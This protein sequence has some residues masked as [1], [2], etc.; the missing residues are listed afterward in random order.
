MRGN[1]I[2]IEEQRWGSTAVPAPGI[3][4]KKGTSVRPWL[5][6]EGSG[7]AEVVEVGKHAIM[8]RT[9]L[10]ARDLRILDPLLSYPSTV[11]G[12]ERA[13]VINLEHIKAIITANQVLLLNSRDPSVTPFVQELQARILR[14][15]QATTNHHPDEGG[16]KIL[17]FEFVALEACLE[18][19]CSVLENEAKTLEQEAHP[20]LDKLT[21]KIS[22]LNLE[23]VRQIKSRLVAITGRVQ[24]V[25]DELEHLLDDDEDMAEMYLTEKLLQQQ[26]QQT[27]SEEDTVVDDTRH[28]DDDNN[29]MDIHHRAEISLEAGVGG[30]V[31]SYEEEED[32]DDDDHRNLRDI[33]GTHASTV[34][35]AATIKLDVEEL[36]M[37]LE[38]YFVQI[39]GTLNKLSTLREYV[40]DTEDY[41]NIMLDDKQNHL[42]QMGVMLTTATLVVS[43]FVVVAGIFGMNI[44]IELFDDKLYGMREFLWTVGGGTAGTIFLYVVAIAWCKHKGLLE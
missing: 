16:I 44:H 10:P 11:L 39:D 6:V 34:Y 21:S 24:K 37:L 9:G 32:N 7:D 30:G 31:A 13:I 4:R 3:I 20:A 28:D 12:R 29:D 27:S 38:A 22:T 35:S 19:A 33:H 17:P 23:R 42:L 18:A 2:G 41:I 1:G 26:S 40:D 43:A 36:E 25:R 8:R 14:H 5:V 15:H